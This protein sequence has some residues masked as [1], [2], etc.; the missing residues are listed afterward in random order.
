[1]DTSTASFSGAGSNL[2]AT[3]DVLWGIQNDSWGWTSFYNHFYAPDLWFHPLKFLFSM[4][5][6]LQ[7]EEQD[8]LPAEEQSHASHSASLWEL[9]SSSSLC[10]CS[11]QP[12][13]QR[14]S[15]DQGVI[16]TLGVFSPLM[17]GA[18]WSEMPTWNAPPAPGSWISVCFSYHNNLK[19]SDKN[20]GTRPRAGMALPWFLPLLSSKGTCACSSASLPSIPHFLSECPGRD[21][22]ADTAELFEIPSTEVFQMFYTKVRSIH[23]A[24]HG[25]GKSA[26]RRCQGKEWTIMSQAARGMA[27]FWEINLP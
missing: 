13:H 12:L 22:R 2:R 3:G 16:T 26:G 8:F 20:A 11:V 24:P 18:G 23:S 1:M 14:N 7:S 9:L 27:N 19:Q 6:V 15:C 21:T 5:L 4:C 10:C 17:K 25:H